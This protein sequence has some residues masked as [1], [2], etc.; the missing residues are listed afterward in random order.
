M[1]EVTLRILENWHF[2]WGT[3]DILSG[4]SRRR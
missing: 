4:M 1:T 3:D 2:P